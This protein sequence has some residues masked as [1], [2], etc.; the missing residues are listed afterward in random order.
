MFSCSEVLTRCLFA[1]RFYKGAVTPEIIEV[2]EFMEMILNDC[3]DEIRDPDQDFPPDPKE[4]A[5]LV[6]RVRDVHKHLE[7]FLH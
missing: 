6:L 4:E 5:F 3:S 1:D 7:K 2:S